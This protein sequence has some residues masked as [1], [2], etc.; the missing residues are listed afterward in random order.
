MG[1][2]IF[3][4]KMIPALLVGAT[5]MAV[6]S[7][8]VGK[9]FGFTNSNEFCTTCHEMAQAV[10]VEYKQTLHYSNESGVRA[11]CPDCH[12]PK[13][14]PENVTSKFAAYSDVLHKIL[15]TVDTPEK[16]EKRRLLMAQR[17]WTHMEET[18]SRECR[19]CHA[20]D[21][22]KLEK[23]G[24]RGRRKHPKAVEE[25]KTCIECHKG[26]V[27]KLPKDYVEPE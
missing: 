9:F 3:S 14:F 10:Y 25:G 20:F 1:N 23:Q 15:G 6:V 5:I 17:V 7:I 22:M 8:G 24:R 11:E 16:F 12:V 18:D 27:H 4:R 21:A 26:V 2:K 13:V 19:T